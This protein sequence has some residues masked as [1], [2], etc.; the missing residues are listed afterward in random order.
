MRARVGRIIRNH[1]PFGRC[2]RNSS[3]NSAC[4]AVGCLRLALHYGHL[5]P[6]DDEINVGIN[7]RNGQEPAPVPE[8]AEHL[9]LSWE[10]LR[11]LVWRMPMR[12]AVKEIQLSDVGPKKM[13]RRMGVD[14][15]PQGYWST[16]PERREKFLVRAYRS[17][18][19]Q[20][21]A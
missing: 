4:S 21:A 17:H 10:Q 2:L 16:P 15:P 9:Q 19:G 18:H 8:V 7:R 13:C 5:I 6:S 14:T 11:N 3:I 1:L 12:E 20:P